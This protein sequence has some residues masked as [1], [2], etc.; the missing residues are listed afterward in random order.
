MSEVVE[1]V[2]VYDADGGW[3]GEV[4]YVVGHLLGRTECALCDVTHSP[5]RRKPAWDA[6]VAGLPVP[7][8][9]VHRNETSDGERAAVAASG[10]PVV[11]GR[12]P[13][14]VLDVLLDR[15]ALTGLD[16]SVEAFESRLR[17]ALDGRSVA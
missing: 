10:L 15:A 4:A 3:R 7:V 2:G 13:D 14:G 16:G 11:L 9:V 12:R 5:V 17:R 6:M 1:V 8:R